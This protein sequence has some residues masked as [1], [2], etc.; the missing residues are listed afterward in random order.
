M[1]DPPAADDL[2]PDVREAIRYFGHVDDRAGGWLATEMSRPGS[3]E[4]IIRLGP[5]FDGAALA[6]LGLPRWTKIGR[7]A[8]ERLTPKGRAL[9]AL[10]FTPTVDRA[11]ARWYLAREYGRARRDLAAQTFFGAVDIRPNPNQGPCAAMMGLPHHRFTVAQ[12]L[13]TLPLSG[14]DRDICVCSYRLVSFP[15]IERE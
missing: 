2:L 14:C 1:F 5:L 3:G 6:A 15:E 12:E 13:P 9:G 4:T 8:W 7:D 10:G 11:H